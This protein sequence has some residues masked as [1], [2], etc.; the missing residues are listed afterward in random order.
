MKIMN[1]IVRLLDQIVAQV[2]QDEIVRSIVDCAKLRDVWTKRH[3]V[4]LLIPIA[5]LH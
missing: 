1:R 5:V 4:Y 3:G 2:Q